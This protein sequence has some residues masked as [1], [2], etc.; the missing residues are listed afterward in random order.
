MSLKVLTH[1]TIIHTYKHV[2]VDNFCED[3]TWWP[4]YPRTCENHLIDCLATYTND[5]IACG[6]DL[7]MYEA[8][9][10]EG[11]DARMLSFSGGGHK[12]PENQFAWMV[13]C[14][15]I[16][17]SC[18]I[19]CE[20]KFL[21]C[22]TSNSPTEFERCETEL[23][24]GALVGCD[25]GCAPTL[26]MLKTSETPMIN[27][28]EGKFGTQTG[29]EK[30]SDIPTQPDCKNS[31]GV[32]DDEDGRNKCF[33]P[34]GVGPAGGAI[35]EC[36]EGEPCTPVGSSCF[37]KNKKEGGCDDTVCESKVCEWRA[38]C[39]DSKY[40]QKCVDKAAQLCSNTCACEE[41]SSNEFYFKTKEK[42]GNTIIITKSCD[43]LSGQKTKKVEKLCR[44]T[45]YVDG[46]QPARVECPKTCNLCT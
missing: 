26:E 3:C 13:G 21:N 8:M 23:K 44:K 12:N 5:A 32:F 41:S 40:S 1:F 31:F 36:G 10:A 19:E 16:V 2:R 29:L 27:L 33:P 7:Y 24:N 42:K 4:I 6:S 45:N 37:L 17:D 38:S 22:I 18:S 34:S 46:Y 35:K 20:T 28:S 39:C 14:L 30:A 11:N 43:W 15:G 9:V 25:P